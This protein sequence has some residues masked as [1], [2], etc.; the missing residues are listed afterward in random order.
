[1]LR[2]TMNKIF[3]LLLFLTVVIGCNK[4]NQSLTGNAS[5]ESAVSNATFQG[6]YPIKIVTTVG[7]VAD[8]VRSVGGEH[9]AVSQMMGASV[10]PHLY[11]PN[12][13]DIRSIM[14]SDYVFY[15]GLML[16]GKMAHVFSKEG[17]KR[18]VVAVTEMISKD[19]LI[20]P[21]GFAG[22]HDPHVW[23]DVSAW[24][25]CV[26]VV[27]KS[28]SKYDD[29]HTDFYNANAKE[30]KAQLELLHAYG[31]KSIGSIPKESRILITSHDAFNYFGRAYGL[32]VQGVQGLSTESESGLQRVNELVDL[33]VAKKV[34]A[35]FVESSVPRKNIEALIEGARFRKHHVVIG[36]KLFSD[37]M[38][39]AG[40]YEG[41]YIGM[42]DHNITLTTRALGGK[43]PIKGMQGKLSLR[44]SDEQ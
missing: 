29:K 21:E 16:E 23:M 14:K 3:S 39:K 10:D 43:A 22:H 36:G 27:A 1:M 6:E 19:F 8:I 41:T 5:E 37:A 9:V 13:D 18:P 4:D 11:K 31:K 2:I 26:D 25:K 12:P 24:S 38:G 20:E 30:Y 44:E 40:T 28:L 32:N 7:M 34:H 35:V 15:S 17:R 42:L 33:I